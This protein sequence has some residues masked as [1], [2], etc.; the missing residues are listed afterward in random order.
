ME[1]AP[2][3][4]AAPRE[5]Q[6]ELAL[7]SDADRLRL[8]V[9]SLERRLRTAE[10][11]AAEARRQQDRLVGERDVLKKTCD[12]LSQEAAH[13]QDGNPKNDL[14]IR[15]LQQERDR[16]RQQLDEAC[17]EL[18]LV[19]TR[20][21]RGEQLRSM[22]E[23]ERH[24]RLALTKQR[25]EMLL[26]F[27]DSTVMIE[28]LRSQLAEAA[29]SLAKNEDER[30]ARIRAQHGVIDDSI[31]AYREADVEEV[32]QVFLRRAISLFLLNNVTV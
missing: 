4:I 23:R 13:R 7:Q 31:P 1:A 9:I 19:T 17:E 3:S 14:Q 5:A 22:L 30:K 11:E 28:K 8:E 12:R 16:L 18:G 27:N 25:D 26:Q 10:A 32:R 24:E 2:A 29:I 6:L 21:E 15:L 20:D